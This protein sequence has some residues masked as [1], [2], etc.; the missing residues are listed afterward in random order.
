MLQLTEIVQGEDGTTYDAP[1]TINLDE[2]VTAGKTETDNLALHLNSEGFCEERTLREDWGQFLDALLPYRDTHHFLTLSTVRD[3]HVFVN[4]KHASE[5]TMHR[6]ENCLGNV[7]W[8]DTE[9]VGP[10]ALQAFEIYQQKGSPGRCQHH[11]ITLEQ[12]SP[13]GSPEQASP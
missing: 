8:D 9:L 12:P 4:L 7:M 3:K 6:V 1:L 10:V 5:V 2:I 13:L 11:P